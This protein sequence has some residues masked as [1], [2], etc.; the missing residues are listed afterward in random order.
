[1]DYAYHIHCRTGLLAL[2]G[3][4]IAPNVFIE[5]QNDPTNTPPAA[6]EQRVVPAPVAFDMDQ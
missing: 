5:I 1:M 3:L 2:F 6:P 4:R